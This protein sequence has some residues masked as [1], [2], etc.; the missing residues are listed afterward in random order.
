LQVLGYSESQIAALPRCED[1]PQINTCA[2]GFGVLYVLEGS[3]LGGQLIA[4]E[5]HAKFGFDER[6][7]AAFFRSHGDNVGKMWLEFCVQARRYVDSPDKRFAAVR[8][9][10]ETFIKIE[11][12]MRK[13]GQNG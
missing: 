4:R 1:L 10:E 5:M 9:A 11:G 8:A 3:T 7:G 6:S 13:A 12:W 2:D